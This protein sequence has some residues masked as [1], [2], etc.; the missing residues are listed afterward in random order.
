MLSKAISSAT[1]VPSF[2]DP[3]KHSE[4]WE[5]NRSPEHMPI[6]MPQDLTIPVHILPVFEEAVTKAKSLTEVLSNLGLDCGSTSIPAAF[7]ATLRRAM[8]LAA[9]KVC[10]RPLELALPR[11]QAIR[12][13]YYKDHIV[14]G[15]R[16]A[17]EDYDGLGFLIDYDPRQLSVSL[18]EM[19]PEWWHKSDTRILKFELTPSCEVLE[20]FVFGY[21]KIYSNFAAKL[22]HR[23]CE[24]T[25]A[26]GSFESHR[27][28]SVLVVWKGRGTRYAG[29]EGSLH[30]LP[31]RL[32]AIVAQG[33]SQSKLRSHD[34]HRKICP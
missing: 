29:T 18:Q 24:Q 31:E 27:R 15:Q 12:L 3:R 8:T 4:R 33:L 22:R 21:A 23:K 11:H 2:N 20:N 26:V 30:K 25:R 14:S 19:I 16:V 34:W 32:G 10:H 5:Y 7:N 6:T 28:A 13:A 1:A 9:E 17:N